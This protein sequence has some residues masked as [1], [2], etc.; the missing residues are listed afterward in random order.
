MGLTWKDIDLFQGSVSINHAMHYTNVNGKM[1]YHVTTPKSESGNRDIPLLMDLRKQLVHL[2]DIDNL[3]GS[4]GTATIDG[5]TDFVFHALAK[6]WE[7]NPDLM[8]AY[9]AEEG[10]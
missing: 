4:H 6:A 5:Y 3:T 2:R 7:D 8:D 1:T 9:D 10:F